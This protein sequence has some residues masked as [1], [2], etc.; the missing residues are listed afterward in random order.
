MTDLLPHGQCSMCS[1]LLDLSRFL[2]ALPLR[3]LSAF[4]SALPLRYLSA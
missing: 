1:I 3:Y 2:S 4:L